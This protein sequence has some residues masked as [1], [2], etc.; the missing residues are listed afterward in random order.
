MTPRPSA[1]GSAR[2][3]AFGP[4]PRL[5]LALVRTNFVGTSKDAA[6]LSFELNGQFHESKIPISGLAGLFP[7]QNIHAWGSAKEIE[8]KNAMDIF[9]A[10]ADSP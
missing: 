10:H 3:Q 2:R 4:L 9:R 1:R 7:L 5:M 6:S 8:L